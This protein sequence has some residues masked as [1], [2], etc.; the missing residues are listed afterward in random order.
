MSGEYFMRTSLYL[1][2]L[3][4]FECIINFLEDIYINLRKMELVEIS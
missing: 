3:E 2:R 4:I 1:V